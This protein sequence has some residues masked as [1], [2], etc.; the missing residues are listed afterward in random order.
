MVQLSAVWDSFK[1][2]TLIPEWFSA[3]EGNSESE[4][5][6]QNH[7]NLSTIQY[8][9]L[10]SWLSNLELNMQ[11]FL[12]EVLDLDSGSFYERMFYRQW[13]EKLLFED[14]ICE[15]FEIY[16]LD[17]KDY[18]VMNLWDE[19]SQ[20]SITNIEGIRLWFTAINKRNGRAYV[21]LADMLLLTEDQMDSIRIW[22]EEWKINTFYEVAECNGLY[23]NIKAEVELSTSLLA[24]TAVVLSLFA[25]GIILFKK[26]DK[27]RTTQLLP[28]Q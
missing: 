9:N 26:S 13:S 12:I 25:L 19:N 6:L 15:G 7:L 28:K 23:R 24:Y 8:N 27:F 2:A 17:I 10:V 11:N 5:F 16:D 21:Q 22:L 4:S 1:N 20:F 18:H 14:G 3:I